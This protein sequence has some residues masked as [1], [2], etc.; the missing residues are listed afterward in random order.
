MALSLT[1]I[2]RRFH[3]ASRDD[4]FDYFYDV[5]HI[6][7]GDDWQLTLEDAATQSVLIASRTEE[8][9]KRP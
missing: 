3:R 2:L 1:S 6:R 9:E 4:G 7:A 8:Y 5:E